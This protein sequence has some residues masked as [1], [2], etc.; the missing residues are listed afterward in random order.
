MLMWVAAVIAAITSAGLA[1]PA[2]DPLTVSVETADADRFAAVFDSANGRPTAEQLQHGYLD[3]GSYGVR[4]F[5]PD[6]II[7]AYH[8]AE[9]VAK[10]PDFYARAINVCLPVVKGTTAELRATYLA[11]RGLFPELPLPRFYLVV[12]ADNSGGTAGPGAQVLGLETLCGL[13]DT[14]EKL[15]EIVR[16][17][18]A[19]ETVH[20]FQ[21]AA[22]MEE[23]D[24]GLL[25]SV[26]VEGAADFIAT[27]VT[28]RQIDPARA[29]W[30]APR[31][32]ELWQQ[33]EADL[34]TTRNMK[35]SARKPGTPAAESFNRWIG[36]YGSAPKGWPTEVGYWMGQRIWQRWYDRQPDKRAAMR[37]MVAL[38]DPAGVFAQGRFQDALPAK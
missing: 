31:E 33:F 23:L 27:L 12:G 8:L 19:H 28:G 20:T 32:A 1:P 30:A 15:R 18:Y 4:V 26:L 21:S 34:A 3:P 37:E 22:G 36:N 10:R 38:T 14:P 7:D 2:A 16:G 11:F 9:A 17:F 5:T 25:S 29:T 13:A 6:R 24:D 35:W